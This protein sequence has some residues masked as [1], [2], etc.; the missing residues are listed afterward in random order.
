MIKGDKVYLRPILK[1]DIS[2]LNKW[3]NDEGI[4]MY[5]GGGFN[6]TSINQQEKWMDSMIDN[7]GDNKRF[8]ICDTQNTPNGLIGLYSIN[9]I[10]RTCEIGVY[11]GNKNAHG[12]GYGKRACKLIEQ[13]AREYLNIRKIKLNVV[14]EN[15][16]AV[17]LWS[18]L[19]YEQVGLLKKERYIKG[20][21][22]DLAIM[23]KFI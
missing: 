22:K 1:E 7:T 12:K 9:W 15:E 3:K 11:I 18:E 17:N 13:Y 6:P 14:V 4:Y 2:H 16:N 8:I 21:Y 20:D 10:H 5:L 19:D 23:E